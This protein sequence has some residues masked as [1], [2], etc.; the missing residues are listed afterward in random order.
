MGARARERERKRERERERESESVCVCA[1]AQTVTGRM[2]EWWCVSECV[3]LIVRCTP[4]NQTNGQR[5]QSVYESAR[6]NLAAGCIA[7]FGGCNDHPRRR[8]QDEH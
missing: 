1:R 3:Q 6:V 4:P 2:F 5:P 8:G 7:A